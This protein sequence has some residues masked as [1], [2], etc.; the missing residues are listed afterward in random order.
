MTR[1]APRLRERRWF[2]LVWAVPTAL[3]L[4]ALAVLVARW[5]V[6]AQSGFLDLYPGTVP[7]P[8]DS[9]VGFPAWLSWQHFLN[10]FFLLFIV[11]SG[12]TIRKRERP[13]AFVTRRVLPN[14]GT[15]RRMPVHVWWHLTVDTLWTLNGVVYV[16]LLFATGQWVRIVPTSWDVIPNAVSAG[17]QYLSLDWP[18]HDGW[19]AYNALQLL[20]YFATVFLAAP[21]ALLTGLRLSPLWRWRNPPE[22][23]ARRV[24]FWVLVYLVA[25]TIVHVA[26]VLANGA[27][28]NL[29]H[30]YAGRDDG[31]WIGLGVFALS[32]VAMVVGWVLLGVPAQ[33]R[34]AALTST[35]R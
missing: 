8:A 15:P 31:S 16:V 14:V 6:R 28:R 27:L 17:L 13:P 1:P 24:H 30:I 18:T 35:V 2:P 23:L 10:G 4:L 20:F 32:L 3:V 11:R 29:N 26:L 19:T 7:L 25:F 5:F 22:A 9:P 34:I 33:K 12:L 21:L